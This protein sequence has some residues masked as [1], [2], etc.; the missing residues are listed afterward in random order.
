MSD[1]ISSWKSW[2]NINTV[3]HA[4]SPRSR[5]IVAHSTLCRSTVQPGSPVRPRK[6][7]SADKPK[8]RSK[9]SMVSGFSSRPAIEAGKHIYRSSVHL[10]PFSTT[11]PGP[12]VP[13]A[14]AGCPSRAADPCIRPVYA[15]IRARASPEGSM[16]S[17]SGWSRWRRS[18]AWC[19]ATT[20]KHAFIVDRGAAVDRVRP[21]HAELLDLSGIVGQQDL[22]AVE[23]GTAGRVE[24]ADGIFPRPD[25][26]IERRSLGTGDRVRAGVET[27]AAAC[28]GKDNEKE[29]RGQHPFG[30]T[31]ENQTQNTSFISAS[32]P[33]CPVPPPGGR[34]P[35]AFRLSPRAAAKVARRAVRS[36]ARTGR[37]R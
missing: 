8:I 11:P 21:R 30:K 5:A 19:R 37:R 15:R 24:R 1:V 33:R 4:G 2:N 20:A 32:V 6:R 31:I 16:R 29:H 3:S 23:P 9:K 28:A 13:R 18:S 10:V 14:R 34:R 12:R 17:I 27:T 36:I 26:A 35:G 7:C 22:R 25:R